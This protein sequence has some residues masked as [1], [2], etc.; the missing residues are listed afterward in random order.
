MS[1]YKIK[2]DSFLR[3]ALLGTKEENDLE[4]CTQSKGSSYKREK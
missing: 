4:Y 2:I 1:Y 3:N